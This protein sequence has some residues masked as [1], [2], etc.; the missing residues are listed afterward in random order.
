LTAAW[1]FIAQGSEFG[2][3]KIGCP[4]EPGQFF[5]GFCTTIETVIEAPGV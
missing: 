1:G 3:G 5:V 2:F 4:F